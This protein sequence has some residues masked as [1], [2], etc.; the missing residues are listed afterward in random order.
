[1]SEQENNTVENST[2]KSNIEL[3]SGEVVEILSR[4]PVW[5]IRWGISLFLIFVLFILIG[6]WVFKYPEVLTAKV[7]LVTEIPP[8][9]L[10]AKTT[11]KIR[12]ISV[13]DKQPVEVGQLLCVIENPSNH[14]DVLE[15]KHLIDSIVNKELLF[16][17][18]PVTLSPRLVSTRKELSPAGKNSGPS[19]S[20]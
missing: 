10:H 20:L 9:S 5:L 11:G 7:E 3:R 18:T 1:M 17:E 16:T 4:Q 13:E 14:T 12:H 6:S 19:K 2:P 8:A 15:V